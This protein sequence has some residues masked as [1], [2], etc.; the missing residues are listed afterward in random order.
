MT[1]PYV[2][3]C[4]PLDKGFLSVAD[5][6]DL[7]EIFSPGELSLML[8]QEGVATVSARRALAEHGIELPLARRLPARGDQVIFTDGI[9][10]VGAVAL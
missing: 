5:P 10:F 7:S 8:R 1:K 2:Y 3:V 4:G 6:T 9:D